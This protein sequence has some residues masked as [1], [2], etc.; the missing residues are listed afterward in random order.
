MR[1][2]TLCFLV[3]GSPVDRLVL[4]YK[5]RGFGKGKYNGFGGKVAPLESPVQGAV[6]ELFEEARVVA[7]EEDLVQMAE[8]TFIYPANPDYDFHVNVYLIALWEGVPQETEEMAPTWFETQA[9]PFERMWQDDRF[10]LPRILQGE[11]V[12]ARVVFHEDNETVA[13]FQ[14]EKE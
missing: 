5:K 4:G 6:R 14:E 1:E 2:G 8:L 13:L 10:W 12:H 3:E 7:R 9:I 11:Y